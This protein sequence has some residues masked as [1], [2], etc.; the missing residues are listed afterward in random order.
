MARVFNFG[1]GPAVLPEPVLEQAKEELLDWQNLG[2]S[3]MEVSHRSGAFK[4]LLKQAENDLRELLTIPENY[5][6]LFLS[7]PARAQFANIPLNLL[8]SDTTADY[9]DTGMWSH[10]AAKEAKRYC[11]VN[12][13]ASARQAGYKSIP[14][15]SQWD[16]NPAAA[17][18]YYTAN[19]TVNGV[20]FHQIPE[21]IEV[22]LVADM[23]STFLSRPVD[24]SRFGL[25]FAGAQKNFGP[26]GLT[27]VIVRDDLLGKALPYTPSVCD[28]T[29]VGEH[30]SLYYTPAS[31]NCYLVALVFRWMKAQGGLTKLAEINQRKAHKLYAFLDENA[32]YA[33][34][35]D[36]KYRSWMNVPFKLANDELDSEFLKQAEQA[37]LCALKGHRSVGGMRASLYNALPEKGVDCLIEFMEDF[38]KRVSK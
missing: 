23:T 36:P 16:L 31:F 30:S 3:V 19:E 15:S 14:C 29:L 21:A 4:A 33:N 32:F 6:V 13:V 2:M 25:I 7:G 34:D 17:Y 27:I 9:M 18:C 26:A 11:Q 22:P 38:A 12:T 20:E 10:A 28:Y 37:G 24:V 5:H 8:G 1:A 35:I